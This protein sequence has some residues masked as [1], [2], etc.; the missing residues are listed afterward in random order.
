MRELSAGASVQQVSTALVTAA[1]ITMFKKALGKP[2]RNVS[3]T[4]CKAAVRTFA[5]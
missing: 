4:S 2:P 5:A 3:A 1:F